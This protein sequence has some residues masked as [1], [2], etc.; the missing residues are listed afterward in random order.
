[1]ALAKEVVLSAAK[2]MQLTNRLWLHPGEVMVGHLSPFP[3]RSVPEDSKEHSSG[4]KGAGVVGQ[5]RKAQPS[6]RTKLQLVEQDTCRAEG[7]AE[8][9][10]PTHLQ[11]AGARDSRGL[12]A[13]SRL[14]S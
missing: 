1:M 12:C 4:A 5:G 14:M 13:V 6:T 2:P 11:P 7:T 10:P 8:A 9:E 3:C